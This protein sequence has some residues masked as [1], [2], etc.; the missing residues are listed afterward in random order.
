MRAAIGILVGCAVA[1]CRRS[2]PELRVAADGS[3]TGGSISLT[4]PLLEGGR[5]SAAAPP[6]P[7]AA[8]IVPDRSWVA[9]FKGSKVF[10]E[11]HQFGVL[12]VAFLPDGVHGLSSGADDD[13]R[14]WDLRT[15]QVTNRL[16]GPRFDFGHIVFTRDGNRAVSAGRGAAYWE[17]STGNVVRELQAP[18]NDQAYAVALSHDDRLAVSGSPGV[19]IVWDLEDGS[20]VNRL[21]LRGQVM[22]LRFGDD[23]RKVHAVTDLS[24]CAADTREPSAFACNELPLLVTG[25]IVSASATDEEILLGNRYGELFLWEGS[26]AKIKRHW[27]AQKPTREILGID[28]RVS[29]HRAISGGDSVVH[30]W[31]TTRGASLTE[32]PHIPKWANTVALSD[33]GQLA[34]IGSE[35]GTVHL[36]RL[37]PETNR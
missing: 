2:T 22:S 6:P 21:P 26:A 19:V 15:G 14:V 23:D 25:P 30:L 37:P 24:V 17:V 3:A 36:W 20:V 8:A 35:G 4:T 16:T 7:P 18:E 13:A 12:A 34:L 32:L 28:F 10:S 9:G 31:D 27:Q 33:D 11:K 1:S 5:S 29:T